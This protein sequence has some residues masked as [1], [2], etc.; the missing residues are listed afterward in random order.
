M[1]RYRYRCVTTEN[2]SQTGVAEASSEKELLDN[3]RR[4]GLIV[5][6]ISPV[7]A[8][9]SVWAFLN[10]D[11]ALAS[12]IRS[13]SLSAL[14]LEWG[15]LIQAGIPIE[16]TLSLTMSSARS[17]REKKSIQKLWAGVKGGASL[18]AA[19][20]EQSG[21]FPKSFVA[22][23][24]AAEASG[25]LGPSLLRLAND[26]RARNDI[27]KEVRNSLIYPIF[28]SV[29]ATSSIAVLLLVVVPNLETLFI[30]RDLN[31]LPMM[32][33][34]VIS[35]S[36][37]FR[38][39]GGAILAFLGAVCVGLSAAT[40]SRVGRDLL[41]K[42][43]LK[44]P[45]IGKIIG[46]LNI[47]HYARSLSALLGGGIVA[48]QA[49]TLAVDTVGNTSLRN[50]I[51]TANTNVLSGASLSTSLEQTSVMPADFVNLVRIGE[52]TGKLAQML[53]RGASLH[54]GQALR[55]LKALT[56]LITPL[57]T[58][59][60]GALAGIIVYAMLSTILSINELAFQ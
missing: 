32:T 57:L 44:L 20:S 29:T 28:L 2:E 7:S 21:V 12:K 41:D 46:S 22:I 43:V 14:A 19:M 53:E 25:A 52:R 51:K 26:L 27:G 60:F 47:G 39:S 37:I 9:N 3:L 15:S 13:E 11:V 17:K 35:I 49:L 16:E 33:R 8:A 59:V 6:R 23:V 55:Q 54:E 36:R 18:H 34:Y 30:G 10:K 24:Q 38:D 31:D 4:Q 42:L 56:S 58:I 40:Y 5:L 45:V 50:A 48:A 1:P